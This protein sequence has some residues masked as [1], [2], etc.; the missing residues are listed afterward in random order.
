[1]GYRYPA[2]VIR[3]EGDA[4][5]PFAGLWVEVRQL[6][7]GPEFIALMNVKYRQDEREI[8]APYI[9][10]WN[11]E[12]PDSVDVTVPAVVLDGKEIIPERTRTEVRYAELEPPAVA[13]ADVFLSVP[14]EVEQWVIGRLVDS[15]TH[16][17]DDPK[18]SGRIVAPAPLP[19]SAP[20]TD[21]G[22]PSATPPAPTNATSAA[23]PRRSR[24]S[25]GKP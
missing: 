14:P 18:A 4:D 6:R 21:D 23:K 12:G 1:M 2:P 22:S 20:T 10:G 25:S 5:S 24:Q 9:V 15:L 17:P 11:V 16:R 13:G 8:A 7:S 19:S 3:Y